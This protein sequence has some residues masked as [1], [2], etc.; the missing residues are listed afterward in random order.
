MALFG[1]MRSGYN[2]AP[3]GLLYSI[4]ILS[5]ILQRALL[6]DANSLSVVS[7]LLVRLT[8]VGLLG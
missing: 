2:R 4:A 5:S 3:A 7:K 1:V 8:G 6:I